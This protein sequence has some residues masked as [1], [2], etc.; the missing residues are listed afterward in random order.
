MTQHV[1]LSIRHKSHNYGQCVDIVTKA[2]LK[3]MR[4][5]GLLAVLAPIVVG[6]FFKWNYHFFKDKFPGY[7]PAT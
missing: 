3:E 4:A 2:A 5:P 7:E 6:L 1:A